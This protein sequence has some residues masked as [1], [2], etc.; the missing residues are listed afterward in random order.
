ML[1]AKI[2]VQPNLQLEIDAE[3]P[4]ELFKLI[5]ASQE[6]FMAEKECGKCNGTDL[7]F[8]VRIVDE[9]EYYELKCR[10]CGAV[11]QYGQNKKGGGLFPKRYGDDVDGDNTKKKLL[12]NRGWVKWNYEKRVLE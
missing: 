8:V 11:F 1:K 5:A 6:V 3:K 9:N 4:N 10:T 7:R 2:N 12:P